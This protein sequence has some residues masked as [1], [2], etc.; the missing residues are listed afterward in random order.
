M[1]KARQHYEDW[2]AEYEA[3]DNAEMKEVAY[4]YE[5]E[6]DKEWEKRI[7][8]GKERR[9]IQKKIASAIIG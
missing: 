5:Q 7:K 9:K 2:T 6:C 3:D 1:Q 4:W 8:E